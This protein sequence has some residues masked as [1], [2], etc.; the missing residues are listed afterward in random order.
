MKS[1][2]QIQWLLAFI[3]SLFSVSL[4]IM[5]TVLMFKRLL[6]IWLITSILGYGSVWAFDGHVDE[7]NEHQ[8]NVGSV[9]HAPDDDGDQAACDHCCH[10]SAHTMALTPFQSSTDYSGACIGFTPYRYTI[11]FLSTAPPDQ[12]PRS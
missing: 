8:D 6:M 2:L 9:G 7:V 11:S 12:P 1:D 4:I 3:D 10:A 5:Y